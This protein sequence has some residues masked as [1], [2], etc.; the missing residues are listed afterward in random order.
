MT[1]TL[2]LPGQPELLD[3]ALATLQAR[4]Y[5]DIYLYVVNE[6][7]FGGSVEFNWYEDPAGYRELLERVVRVGIRPVVW[8]APDD[9]PRFHR[10]S[11]QELPQYWQTFIPAIDDLVGSYVLGLEMDEYWTRAEQF[12]LANALSTAKPVFVHLEAG[13]RGSITSFWPRIRATGLV[14]Q[15]EDRSDGGIREE[16]DEV[17]SKL[18][19]VGKV[20]VAGEYAIGVSESVARA[21]GDIAVTHGAIGYGNGGTR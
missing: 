12:R 15:Y 5:T 17:V 4:N 13:R 7:D 14:Y 8:L 20:V 16:T 11:A 10:T 21:R 19:Q 3:L 2:L 6:G 9:A 1:S 18:T